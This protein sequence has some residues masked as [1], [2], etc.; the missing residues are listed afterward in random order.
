VRA[1]DTAAREAL[2]SS[3]TLKLDPSKKGTPEDRCR[4]AF[5]NGMTP[6]Q[7]AHAAG[8]SENTAKRWRTKFMEQ[9][10]LFG[11]PQPA[12]RKRAMA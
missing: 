4:R 11:I 2:P 12:T 9:E 5:R 1:C 8:V 3:P 10:Q 6:E 7:L